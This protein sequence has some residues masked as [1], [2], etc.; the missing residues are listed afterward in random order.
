[1]LR[2]QASVAPTL[3]LQHREAAPVL[4]FSDTVPPS[5]DFTPSAAVPLQLAAPGTPEALVPGAAPGMLRMAIALLVALALLGGGGLAGGHFYLNKQAGQHIAAAGYQADADGLLAAL[6]EGHADLIPAFARLGVRVSNTPRSIEAA[7]VSHSLPT[8]QAVLTGGAQLAN[9][10]N[11]TQFLSE[12][13]ESDDAGLLDALL[14][15]QPADAGQVVPEVVHAVKGE[16]WN[17]LVRLAK[18]PLFQKF[19]STNGETLAHV[20]ALSNSEALIEAVHASAAVDFDAANAQGQTPL[21]VAVARQNAVA[22]AQ[23]LRL[24]ANP[25]APDKA[26]KSALAQVW[27]NGSD[28]VLAAM[29]AQSKVVYQTLE[30]EDLSGVFKG[31]YVETTKA[32]L[33]AGLPVNQLLANGQTPLACAAQGRDDTVVQALLQAGADPNAVSGAGDVGNVTALMFA[34][35]H[36][37]VLAA[38]ALLQ[39]RANPDVAASNGATARS[40]ASGRGNAELLSLLP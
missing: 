37:N 20:A 3:D 34:A 1:M 6:S 35:A 22:V 17:A 15:I 12:A 21:H 36:D 40:I 26:G 11:R 39:G 23:L 5:L 19:V 25:L 29:V 13:I 16:K 9:E 14:A 33:A 30:K 7:L 18:E 38:K 4:A 32:L 8:L 31:G 27:E 10:P 24:G 2:L 28:S